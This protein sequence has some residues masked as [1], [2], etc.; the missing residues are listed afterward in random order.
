MN[1]LLEQYLNP[2]TVREEVL[3]SIYSVRM[4]SRPAECLKPPNL[5]NTVSILS[6]S[7]GLE[8]PNSTLCVTLLP[9]SSFLDTCSSSRRPSARDR[10]AP[11]LIR[12]PRI[13]MRKTWTVLIPKS[14]KPGFSEPFAFEEGVYDCVVNISWSK[15][16]R[17]LQS[18]TDA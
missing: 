11:S 10:F 15:F 2:R 7:S 9:L 13:R 17:R 6:E 14:A 5:W 12:G 4:V 3:S 8:Y 1:P 18:I 16:N